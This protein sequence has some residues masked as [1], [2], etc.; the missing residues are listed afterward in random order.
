MEGSGR[1]FGVVVLRV[2][3]GQNL[4]GA[5]ALEKAAHAMARKGPRMPL[6]SHQHCPVR[7]GRGHACFMESQADRLLQMSHV[8]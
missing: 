2:L 6:S 4:A 7:R 5:F 8:L 3:G 1:V